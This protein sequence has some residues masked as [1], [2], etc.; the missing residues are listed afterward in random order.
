MR[1]E[2]TLLRRYEKRKN[3]KINRFY[4]C[5]CTFI[6]PESHV[7]TVKPPAATAAGVIGGVDGWEKKKK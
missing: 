5:R 3:K 4:S 6:D 1:N 7:R 2:N